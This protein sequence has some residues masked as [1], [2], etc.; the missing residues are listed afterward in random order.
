MTI[1]VELAVQ[2]GTGSAVLAALTGRGGLAAE[3]SVL[4]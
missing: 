4:G 2:G 3:F 1:A